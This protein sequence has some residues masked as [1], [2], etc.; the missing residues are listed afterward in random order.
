MIYQLCLTPFW[1]QFKPVFNSFREN[2]KSK[3]IFR[4]IFS[5]FTDS[6]EIIFC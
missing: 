6:Q 3:N 2:P 1:L 4:L 5:I